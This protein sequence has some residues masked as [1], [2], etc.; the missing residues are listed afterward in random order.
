MTRPIKGTS[1]ADRDPS[2]LESS[3]KDAAELHMIVDLMRNDLGRVC[4]VGT[5]GVRHGRRIE[6]HP[7]VHHG[8]GEVEVMGLNNY[9]FK[10]HV[11]PERDSEYA[12]VTKRLPLCWPQTQ[13]LRK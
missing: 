12:S 3:S 7:T 11:P 10:V 8:V 5:V 9:T 13:S 6:S 1:A 2:E 4:E